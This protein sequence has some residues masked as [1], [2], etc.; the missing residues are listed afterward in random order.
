MSP[1]C[2]ADCCPFSAAEYSFLKLAFHNHCVVMQHFPCGPW[3]LN[4]CDV[5]RWH[6]AL[7]CLPRSRFV[8]SLKNKLTML[9]NIISVLT[10]NYDPALH[11]EL[12]IPAPSVAE[13]EVSDK[14]P[15]PIVQAR[16][17]STMPPEVI[18]VQ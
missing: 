17:A 18:R 5:L 4:D 10:A 3:D 2:I 15:I 8:I 6:P 1:W 14:V 9:K 16:R 7:N 11:D 13:D 12:E